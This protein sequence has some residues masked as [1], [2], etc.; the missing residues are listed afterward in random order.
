MEI[1]TYGEKLPQFL[2]P[3]DIMGEF[4]ISTYPGITVVFTGMPVMVPTIESMVILEVKP[5]LKVLGGIGYLL[6]M[7]V[8]ER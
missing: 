5:T 7:L 8:P 2:I 4:L 1:P 3:M 6:K